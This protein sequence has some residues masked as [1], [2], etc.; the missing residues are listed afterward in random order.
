MSVIVAV[1]ENRR[2]RMG[3]DGAISSEDYIA[4]LREPKIFRFG[5]VL[6]GCAGSLRC[7]QVIKHGPSPRPPTYREGSAHY[8]IT[9]IVPA[10]RQIFRETDAPMDD[11]EALVGFRDRI[12]EITPRT[13]AV[14]EIKEDYAAT[15]SGYLVALGSLASTMTMKD[16]ER[17]LLRALT[18]TA[19]HCPTVSEPFYTTLLR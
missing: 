6:M 17:R 4:E 13:F 19:K 16:G 3:S 11:F 14:I 12:F 15:G 8:I 7:A 5:K 9:G 2:I 18:A 10:I 1:V